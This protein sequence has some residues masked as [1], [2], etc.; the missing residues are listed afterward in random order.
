M[1]AIQSVIRRT[2]SGVAGAI[3]AAGAACPLHAPAPE[4]MVASVPE[5]IV[6]ARAGDDTVQPGVMFV[7]AKDSAKTVAVVWIHGSGVNFYQPSY[8]GIGR[9]LAQRG[10]TVISANTREARDIPGWLTFLGQRGLNKVILVGHSAGWTSVR[11]Y[12]LQRDPRVVGLV[13]ASGAIQPQTPAADS[14]TNDFFGFQTRNAGI[15]RVRARLLAFFGTRGDVGGTNDLAQLTAAIQ[16]QNLPIQFT[17]A[18]IQGGDHMYAGQEAQ[19]ADLI[20]RWA[21]G[22]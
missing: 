4:K 17:A 2:M 13:L 12:S 1:F 9:E 18:M 7:P 3:A 14:A 10:Y 6:Y 8:V 22:I 5:Q 21:K 11:Q 19:V 20:A 16:R 15:T